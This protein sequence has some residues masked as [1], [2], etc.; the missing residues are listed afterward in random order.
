MSCCRPKCSCSARLPRPECPSCP[1][2]PPCPPCPAC[3][4]CPSCPPC[5]SPSVPEGWT[6]TGT[7][8]VRTYSARDALPVA[9]VQITVVAVVNNTAV[10]TRTLTTD[11]DG[12]TEE[13]T[14]PCP[15]RALS[16]EEDNTSAVPYAVYN[17]QALNAE[18]DE[19][20]LQDLQVFGGQLTLA[21]LA[22]IPVEAEDENG[23]VFRAE[24]E[25]VFVPP[26][27]LFAG[28][29]GSGPAPEEGRVLGQVVI[30][31]KITVHLGRPS[32]SARNVTVS[33]RDYIKNVASSEVY[34]TWPEQALRANIHA[35]ISLAL[36][37]IYTEW[38]PSRGYSFNITSSPGYDQYYVHG[39]EIFAVMSRI[40]DDIFNT[41]LR[42]GNN[43]EPLFAEYCD[44]KTVSNCPGMKQWGTVTQANAGKNALQILQYYYGSSLQ[45]IRTDN[46]AKIPQSY[47]GTPLRRGDTGTNVRIL[48]R[49]LNRIAKDYPSFGKL[50]NNG[51]FDAATETSVRRFQK[52][53]SLTQD[54]VVGRSTWYKI[55]YIY[56]SVTDLAELTSEGEKPTGELTAGTYPGTALRVGS[57]GDNVSNIQFW[58][59]TV[60]TFVSSI[61]EVSV[62]GVFGSG[63]Q[64]AVTAYQRYKGLAADGVVGRATW[65]ALYADYTSVQNDVSG[66]VGAFPGTTLRP[67][68]SGSDV[69]RVQFFL[70]VISRS[71]S[72]VPNVAI[73]GQFGS[74]TQASVRAFQSAYGLSADGA[75]GRVTWNKLYEVYTSILNGLLSAAERPGTYPGSPLAVGSSGRRVKEM[76][77][78]LYIL[79]A[80]YSAIPRIAFDGVF[81]PATQAAVRAFQGLF[82]LTVDGIVGR[83][84]WDALYAQFTKLRNVDGLVFAFRAFL[85]PGTPV[86]AGSSADDVRIVQWM[87]MYIGRFMDTVLPVAAVTGIYD[88]ALADAVKSFQREFE[89]NITGVVD[90]ETWNAMSITYLSLAAG[91]GEATENGEYP[92]SVLVLGSTGAPVRQLQQY[93]NAIAAQH[94]TPGFLAESGIFDAAMLR[95]IESF[96]RDLNLP[97]TGAVDMATWDAIYNIYANL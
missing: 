12:L 64:A 10:L 66:G 1:A 38:Y 65:N 55:S 80:Y 21:D 59:N 87:L 34:P 76:Q 35:Q 69:R 6:D 97:V 62:D 75:V 63:T 47:P 73:D 37:R 53:F 60:G 43:A 13:I 77:Y 3:P 90:E 95:A 71:N 2:C 83:A 79:S 94:S 67:G 57:S 44:G 16:L 78:Y 88:E 49:W 48:Q 51:V 18:F 52:Q 70:R 17:L 72:A 61:P 26:H 33:F 41:Y 22:L 89:L 27:S 15:P 28:T 93:I 85:Y 5:P 4:A 36:N 11:A 68:S 81:G 45:I 29:G 9:D 91:T 23:E 40:T 56:V 19:Y 96:Q 25:P 84:T 42:R 74:A 7:L 31:E 24:N 58:L 30:P 82:K 14:L 54:G 46:I 20:D 86:Q 50:Q 32:A 39:R 8:R 92:G